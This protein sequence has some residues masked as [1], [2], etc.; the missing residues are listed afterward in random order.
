ML[1]VLIEG[2]RW[3][4]SADYFDSH[5]LPYCRGAPL[6]PLVRACGHGPRDI[7]DGVA[8]SVLLFVNR[9]LTHIWCLQLGS[10]YAFAFSA[11]RTQSWA[12]IKTI[13][14]I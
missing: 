5:F 10:L 13:Q 6:Q 1:W 11:W 8:I 9:S 14:Y 4:D 12:Y 7:T 3:S 2:F